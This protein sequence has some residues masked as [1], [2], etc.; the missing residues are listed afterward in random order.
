MNS[1]SGQFLLRSASLEVELHLTLALIGVRWV[2]V[3]SW[4]RLHLLVPEPSI[5]KSLLLRL[6]VG[7]LFNDVNPHALESLTLKLFHL[8]HGP[9]NV[10]EADSWIVLAWSRIID[11]L[12]STLL[13]LLPAHEYIFIL[14][15][16]LI[17]LG[18]HLITKVLSVSVDQHLEWFLAISK[19]QCINNTYVDNFF[20][21]EEV[22]PSM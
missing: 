6:E 19:L 17:S 13:L 21:L 8:C 9:R 2:A 5:V 15:K 3:S 1:C 12:L 4:A 7:C 22:T 16:H 18:A 20:I 14:L 10:V 11:R